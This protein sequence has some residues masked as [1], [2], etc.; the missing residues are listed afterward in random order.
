MPFMKDLPNSSIRDL[1]INEKSNLIR[2][3]TFGRGIWESDTYSIATG[4]AEGAV[5][6][7]EITIYPNPNPG[8]FTVILNEAITN[9]EAEM[10]VF[11]QL[12]EKV[13]A[14][15]V[16][17]DNGKVHIDISSLPTGAYMLNLKIKDA[18]WHAKILKQ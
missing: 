14:T 16:K 3:G 9:Q 1:E 18:A 5:T 17:L 11:N 10:D 4:I 2:A 8:I 13:Y 15:Q 6:S 12:G 7:Q